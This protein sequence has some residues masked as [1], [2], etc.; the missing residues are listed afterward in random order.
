MFRLYPVLEQDNQNSQAAPANPTPAEAPPP[1]LEQMVGGQDGFDLLDSAFDEGMF[2]GEEQPQEGEQQQAG[3]QPQEGEQQQQQKMP[4][5]VLKAWRKIQQRH[6]HQ[7]RISQE[8]AAQKAQWEAEIGPVKALVHSVRTG[9]MRQKV[10][11]LSQLA[12]VDVVDFFREMSESAVGAQ[13]KDEPLELLKRLE[14]RFD[15]E[16]ARRDQVQ[17]AR[18]ADANILLTLNHIA[19]TGSMAG[20]GGVYEVPELRELVSLHPGGANAVAQEMFQ[21]GVRLH[22]QGFQFPVEHAPAIIVQQV[23]SWLRT[24]DGR[25]YINT[26]KQQGGQQT[27]PAAGGRSTNPPATSLSAGQAQQPSVVRAERPLTE[28]E[29]EEMARAIRDEDIADDILGMAGIM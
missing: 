22:Q 1:Q 10:S 25:A 9:D 6:A 11:A 20:G 15:D 7:E 29:R 27:Q 3:E 21:T 2:P 24:P 28:Q 14:K 12:G 26:L 8:L 18:Q 19:S 4:P 17:Q 13:K 16:F 23:V 5:E